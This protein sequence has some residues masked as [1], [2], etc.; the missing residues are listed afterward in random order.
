MNILFLGYK[1]C[2]A[3]DFLKSKYNV[4]QLS[5]RISNSSLEVENLIMLLVMG[6]LIFLKKI[7]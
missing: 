5:E 6:T 3:L 1:S 7:F 4:L 2:K